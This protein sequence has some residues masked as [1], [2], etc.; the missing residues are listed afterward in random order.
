[1][2]EITEDEYEQFKVL[3]KV[4]AHLKYDKSGAYFICGDLGRRNDTEL[5][6]YILI[7]P[8]YG[9]DFR[10]VTKYKRVDAQN[11]KN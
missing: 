5:P 2:V 4:W 11:T 8:N 6:E 7:C 10:D 9:A 3:K 1:M